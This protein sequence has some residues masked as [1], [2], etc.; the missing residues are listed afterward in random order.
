LKMASPTRCKRDRRDS[1]AVEHSPRHLKV[2]GLSPA[3]AV[4]TGREK[5]TNYSIIKL[6][7]GGKI[8]LPVL[9][10]EAAAR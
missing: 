1:T 4:D 7:G 8:S 9:N 3:A 6:A 10:G 2:E 5:M